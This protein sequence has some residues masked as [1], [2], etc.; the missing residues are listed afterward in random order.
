[1]Q[2]LSWGALDLLLELRYAY[3]VEELEA[4]IIGDVPFVLTFTPFQFE[5]CKD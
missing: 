3:A 5:D 1:M 4:R 2:V